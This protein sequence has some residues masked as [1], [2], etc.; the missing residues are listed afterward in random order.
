MIKGDKRQINFLRMDKDYPQAPPN[1]I[2]TFKEKPHYPYGLP[3]STLLG[4]RRKA[5]P[6]EESTRTV[7]TSP[8]ISQLTEI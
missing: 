3:N 7:G 6:L 1:A 4:D 2:Q 5:A 8:A